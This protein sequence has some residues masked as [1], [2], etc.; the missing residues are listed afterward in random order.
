MAM[1]NEALSIR[2]VEKIQ[3]KLSEKKIKTIKF[4]DNSFWQKVKRNFL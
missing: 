2:Q 4:K 3:I 1:D